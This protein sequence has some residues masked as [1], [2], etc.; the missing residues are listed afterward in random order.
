M[1]Y[2]VVFRYNQYRLQQEMV[3]RIRCGEFHDKIFILKLFH[4]ERENQFLRLKDSELSYFGKLYDVIAERKSGDTTLFYC[5]H[6]KKE[7]DLI[8]DY[9]LYLK[10]NGD[11]RRKDHSILAMLYNLITQALVQQNT[12]AIQGQGTP[13][14]FCLP[15]QIIIPVYIVHFAPPPEKV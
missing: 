5:L 15:H 3:S 13:V 2:Y 14:H 9:S 12:L 1:G 11:T 7:E 4:P 6:D 8:A 10:H